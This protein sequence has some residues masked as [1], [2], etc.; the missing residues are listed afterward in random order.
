[1]ASLFGLDVVE[2]GQVAERFEAR[3]KSE[4]F[5]AAFDALRNTLSRWDAMTDKQVFETDEENIKEALSDFNK[6]ITDILT[7]GEPVTKGLY[8]ARPVEKAGK[9]LSTKNKDALQGIYDSLGK[10]LAGFSEQ[11]DAGDGGEGTGDVNKSEV[12]KEGNDMTKQEIT[13]IVDAVVEKLGAS[14]DTKEKPK[15]DP[16]KEPVEKSAGG[17][18][19]TMESIQKMVD[20]AV[21]KAAQPEEEEITKED[22]GEMIEEAVQKA[23]EPILK[24]RGIPSSLND[25]GDGVQKGA[26]QHYLHGI[27]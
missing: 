14:T 4:Q 17:E 7:S 23:M 5:W 22:V 8:A 27:L 16:E 21:K 6:I 25:I 18:K 11:A 2:K 26:E 1:M 3:D 13:E 20:A 15:E 12:E 19:I 24:A 9:S 10:F